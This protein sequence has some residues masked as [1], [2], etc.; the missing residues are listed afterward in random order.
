MF[1]ESLL[2]ECTLYFSK[3]KNAYQEKH[4][5]SAKRNPPHLTLNLGGRHFI[6]HFSF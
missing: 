2:L 6:C 4:V 1:E 5:I 3:K